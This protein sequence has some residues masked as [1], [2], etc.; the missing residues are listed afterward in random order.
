M[1][2]TGNGWTLYRGD[3]TERALAK[4]TFDHLITDP[5]Y[6][7]AAEGPSPHTSARRQV[8]K[9]EIID[10]AIPFAA[11]T[12][13]LRALVGKFAGRAARWSLVFCQAEGLHEYIGAFRA[14]GADYVR[15]IAW[16]KPDGAPQFTGDRP[17]QGFET[18]AVAHRSG[19]K[20][21]WN[22]GGKRGVYTHNV[23]PGGRG[24]LLRPTQKPI[25]LMADLV[26]DFTDPGET[27]FDPFTGSGST[28]VASIRLGRRFYGVERD[29]SAFDLAVERL[30][31]EERHLDLPAARAGQLPLLPP[32]A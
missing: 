14:H 15:S 23:Q 13:K 26:R 7:D 17:A 20:K 16:V 8:R 27:V 32:V 28:G 4:V 21:A 25:A 10:L 9:G 30:R 11:I 29:A 2:V 19:S 12:P 24:G 3:A 6:E 18:I 5:P 31:A 1:I 22:A